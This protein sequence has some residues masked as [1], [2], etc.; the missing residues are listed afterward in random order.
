MRTLFA[1]YDGSHGDVGRPWPFDAY[2]WFHWNE[3]LGPLPF[4]LALLGSVVLVRRNPPQALV[5]LSFPLT[6][7]I[8]LMSMQTHF[9]RNLLPVQPP[10]FLLAGVGAVALFDGVWAIAS[11]ALASRPRAIHLHPRLKPALAA[12]ALVLL[13]LSSF[14]PAVQS[15]A[16]LAQ[17]DS[18]VAA[19]EWARRE[20]PGVRIASEQSHP[21]RWD[22]VAQSTYV[23]YLPLRSLAWYREQ[24]YGLLMANE[25]KRK[26]EY[27][28]DDYQPLITQGKIVATFGGQNSGYLG[29]R[30]D[31]IATGL[32]PST[33]PSH[34]PRAQVG[35]LRLLG[36]VTGTLVEDTS[37][38]E[39]QS[40]E[41]LHAGDT[42]ALTAFWMADQPVSP[43]PAMVFVHLR[44]AQGRTLVQRDAPPWLG[45][46]PLHQWPVGELVS[47]SLDLVLPESL[48]PGQ[49]RLVLGLYDGTTQARFVASAG[50]ERLPHDEVDLGEVTIHP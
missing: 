19:Q 40:H 10:L 47:E 28:T 43:Q 20:W 14:V 18:R 46:F 44:D 50:D 38:P 23:H 27:W 29:P 2:L 6:L 22:G 3:G 8:V 41:P 16:R 35:P 7:L 4:L 33:I 34:T 42:L 31:L 17:P 49:Y 15:S 45:L 21:M 37:G 12:S 30:V 26:R 1:S 5:L 24:G 39:M 13:L 36:V 48:P 9:Y 11:R 25:G 32:T